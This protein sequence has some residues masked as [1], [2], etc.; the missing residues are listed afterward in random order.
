[1]AIIDITEIPESTITTGLEGKLIGVYGGNSTGKTSVLSKL[2]PGQTLWLATENGTN[3]QSKLRV[4]NV[5]DWG[6]FRK[7]VQQLTTKNKKKREKVRAMY[8]CIVLDVADKLPAMSADYVVSNYNT[9]Q[10]TIAE[11]KGREYTPISEIGEIPYGAGWDMWRTEFDSWVDRLYNSGYCV[12]SIFHSELKTFNRDKSD[13]YKQIIPKN[14]A[15]NPGASLRD[16]LDFVIYLEAQGADENGKA[17]L[18]KGYTVEH[19]DFFARSRFTQCPEEINPFTAENLRE[20]IRIAC[21]REIALQDCVGI[22]NDEAIQKK[23]AEAESKKVGHKELIAMIEPVY[24]ALFKSDCKALALSLV[25]EYLGTDE[26]GKPNKVTACTEKDTAILQ[27]LY[28]EFVDMAEEND[29]D[30]EN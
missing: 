8:K 4:G 13:E 20:T 25:G 17:I 30:W 22:T 28:D 23:E 2:F 15:S 3:A 24:K 1:M 21:E 16:G 7:A 9:K 5:D 29:I 27:V 18:S 6:D 10:S 12:C 14:T 19:K 11:R 26:D